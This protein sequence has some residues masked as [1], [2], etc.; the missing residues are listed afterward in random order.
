MLV[1][2]YPQE[3]GVPR[4]GFRLPDG[5]ATLAMHLRSAGLVTAAFVSASPLESSLGLDRGFD[6]YDEDFDTYELDQVQRRAETTASSVLEWL[7]S[8]PPG[9]FFLW[10]HL[11]D[12]HYPYSPP[13]PFDTLFYPEYEGNADGSI[14][15]LSG[16]TGI[17][18]FAKHPTSDDDLRKVI[19]LY[20]GEIAYMDH[21]LGRVLE[22]LDG[23]EL[24][25]STAIIV[26][27][28]HGES[29][30]EHD[31]FFDHGEYVYQPSMSVPLIVRPPGRWPAPARRVV[32]T[33]VQTVDIF[34]T[35]LSLLG[36]PVPEPGPSRDLT[37]L[38]SLATEAVGRLS[39]G[40][41]CRP[42]EVEALYPDLWPNAGKWQFVFEHPWKLVVA[43]Y[44][45]R[46]GLYRLDIDPGELLD[47]THQHPDVVERLWNELRIWR[48]N[49][50]VSEIQVD[51]DNQ[52]RLRALGYVE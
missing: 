45:K 47:L 38:W 7:A 17:R 13:P 1:G 14:E 15:Y 46:G 19:G 32:P 22:V 16:I 5:V 24:R 3:F 30:T 42:W 50:A 21:H 27:A 4:N 51:P 48:E 39:F 33:Q 10:V 44:L 9:P 2:R 41:G 11:F 23:P 35:S 36:Q 49:A 8:R 25:P 18:G 52:D 6:L 12:A 43:P 40:E 28:D 29:L 34:A 26:V 31:Y 20:D 37:P